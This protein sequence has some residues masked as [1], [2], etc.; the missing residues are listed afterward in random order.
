MR[1]AAARAL[2]LATV[3]L[4]AACG[5]SGG[6]TP[7]PTAPSTPAPATPPPAAT[8]APSGSAAE[9]AGAV[10]DL[11]NQQ[12]NTNGLATLRHNT[13]LSEASRLQAE[14]LA[15]LQRLEH[16][17]SG[18]RYPRPEDRLAAA[19]YIWQRYGENLASGQRSA[20]DAVQ[21]WM[22]SPGHRANIVNVNFTEIGA[23]VATDSTGRRY[24]VQMFGTPR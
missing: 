2:L 1:V 9:I 8:P 20:A 15:E 5:G 19:G 17:V 22:D 6:S 7:T 24:Y 11:T 14:Q 10:I 21:D 23:A 13:R 12:R 3:L 4:A 16:E 18:G